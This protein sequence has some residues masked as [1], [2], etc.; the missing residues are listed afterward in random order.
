MGPNRNHHQVKLAGCEMKLKKEQ[1]GLTMVS[2]LLVLGMIGF[3]TMI[4]L[5]L[6]PVYLENFS[7]TSSLASLKEAKG[8]GEVVTTGEL[9]GSL[10]RRLDING[11]ES[12]EKGNVTIVR[13]GNIYVVT[14]KYEVRR[15][16]LYNI[17]FVVNFNDDVS[18]PAY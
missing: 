7:V 13:E 18:V 9:R 3:F 17:D 6:L 2:W 12:V 8:P 15:P 16:F 10:F 14:V 1:Q 5:R 11:V 4:V